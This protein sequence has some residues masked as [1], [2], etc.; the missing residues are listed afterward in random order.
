MSQEGLAD[1]SGVHY[2]YTGGIEHGERNLSIDN[3]GR[4]ADA[5]GLDAVDLL[6]TTLQ[7][8][9]PVRHGP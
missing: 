7:T 2:T 8:V 1:L 3:V 9:L 4:L 5:L 6:H